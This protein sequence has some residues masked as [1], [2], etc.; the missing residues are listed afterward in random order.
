MNSPS[1]GLSIALLQLHRRTGEPSAREI[2]KAIGYSH[3]TVAQALSGARHPSWPV[4]S[5]IVEFLK[6][7]VEEFRNYWIAVRDAEQPIRSTDSG[8]RSENT[9]A[10]ERL[11][12]LQGR[13]ESSTE[14]GLVAHYSRNIA[15]I[16][17]FAFDLGL[18]TSFRRDLET[19]RG[20]SAL[21]ESLHAELANS[22]A[23]Q[24]PLYVDGELVY[25]YFSDSLGAV[26]A[27]IKAALKLSERC[28]G[29][30]IRNALRSA[31][32][33]EGLAAGPTPNE[34]QA[35]RAAQLIDLAHGGQILLSAS[36][37]EAVDGQL[38]SGMSVED[39]GFHRSRGWFRPQRVFQLNH[40]DL[41]SDFPQ[42]SSVGGGE[43]NLPFQLTS[44]IG[45]VRERDEVKH[46]LSSTRLVT[47]T[48]AGGCGKTRLA[49]E[50]GHKL[51]RNYA[52]GIW[53]VEL[54]RL[55]DEPTVLDAVGRVL[56]LQVDG[57][58]DVLQSIREHLRDKNLLLILD[59]CEHVTDVCRR[60]TEEITEGCPG[61]SVLATSREL[62][63]VAGEVVW[64]IPSL[65][66]PPVDTPRS[67]D[68]LRS[69]DAVSLFSERARARDRAFELSE[70]NAEA[71]LEICR[72][73]DGI[74]LAIELAAGWTGTFGPAEV[75]ELLEERLPILTGGTGQVLRHRTLRA[76]IDWSFGLLGPPERILMR[77]LSVFS[78]GASLEAIVAACSGNGLQRTEI[79][80]VLSDLV[81]KS[82]IEPRDI[83]S[84]RRYFMLDTVRE[85]SHEALVQEE[86]ETVMADQLVDWAVKL[87]DRIGPELTSR[88]QAAAL[89]ELEQ[90]V[91]N[92]RTVLAIVERDPAAVDIG[93]RLASALSRFWEVRGYMSEG[94]RWLD[95][96]I[97]AAGIARSLLL[98]R[99]LIA[100][101][102]LAYR[103]SD[104]PVS[105]ER[106]ARALDLGQELN[107]QWLIAKAM[108]GLG[109]IDY[110]RGNYSKAMTR[111]EDSLARSRDIPD[112]ECLAWSWQNV[113]RIYEQQGD[114]DQAEGSQRT[115]LSLR[116]EI[117]DLYS[118]A[119]SRNELGIVL[120]RQGA[121]QSA[122]A[123]HRSSLEMRR[124]I[125]DR[126]GLAISMRDLG[127][128]LADRDREAS[129]RWFRES[130]RIEYEVGDVRGIAL[131]IERIAL[132]LSLQGDDA[133]GT[134]LLGAAQGLR[135]SIGA[136]VEAAEV[137]AY[138]E[139]R[140]RARRNLSLANEEQA[141][142]S[143]HGMSVQ[144]AVEATLEGHEV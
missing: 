10:A 108:C 79:P 70:A 81:A 93:L 75:S 59:T 78:G 95:R 122:E 88:R 37:P 51:I 80:M 30:G 40:P 24:S 118:I 27:V 36:I 8:M 115:C 96:M 104:Y 87:L 92:L 57:G 141:W 23:R 50:V 117:G 137:G 42:I 60:L 61:V 12:V 144:Q 1:D 133:N 67:P 106:Y 65:S 11:P 109:L 132:L 45:R 33:A 126:Q 31:V 123:M 127:Q 85:Y 35:I 138:G 90:E 94:R 54:D 26:D 63:R 125:G 55:R 29:L 119:R 25:C 140:S 130:V 97:D 74:P 64:R 111:F 3:T 107:D 112:R 38:P 110:R 103:Q 76:A 9:T 13:F 20:A 7:D 39:L 46:L 32:Y 66:L 89:S 71:V 116:E 43:N 136:P 52:D 47:L 135:E 114:L 143:G 58:G 44:F 98:G 121:T 99:A 131:C 129:I 128:A 113:G 15:T 84:R 18:S 100:S 5:G 101:G 22:P 34:L 49:V 48:G 120:R 73:L 6:G 14:E 69:Y 77:R 4:L 68:R 2:A 139:I 19:W 124:E 86:E 17:M 102:T 56:K 91:G 134:R 82:V 28:E 53:L 62:L 83:A 72:K 105:G 21:Y 142:L 16:V 41:P